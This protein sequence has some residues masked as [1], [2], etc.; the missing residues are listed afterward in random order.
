MYAVSTHYYS[1]KL[2]SPSSFKIATGMSFKTK[3]ADVLLLVGD[4]A[5]TGEKTKL[6]RSLSKARTGSHIM[7]LYEHDE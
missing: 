3:C 5:N 1:Y 6:I 4:A 7:H 2:H